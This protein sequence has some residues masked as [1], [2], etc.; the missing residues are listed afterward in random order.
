MLGKR[1]LGS[2]AWFVLIVAGLVI[3]TDEQSVGAAPSGQALLHGHAVIYAR[4]RVRR[5]P[6]GATP[7][8]W[9]VYW[10]KGSDPSEARVLYTSTPG[11][12]PTPARFGYLPSPDGRWLH[13]WETVE[14]NPN[15]VKTQWVV[16]EVS[17][18]RR[19]RI[20]ESPGM[21]G[22]L[23]RW[24]DDHRLRLERGDKSAVFD[25]HTGKISNP[26]PRPQ[27][28][29]ERPEYGE[30]E[31]DSSQAAAAAWRRSYVQR[32]YARDETLL[33]GMQKEHEGELAISPYLRPGK[34][35][36][37]DT[38]ESLL[39]RPL[40]I[41]NLSGYMS[42][43]AVWP[44]VAISPDAKLLARTTFA[45]TGRKERTDLGGRAFLGYAFDARL[46]VYA[47]PSGER[48]WG[49]VVSQSNPQSDNTALYLTHGRLASV[50]D[51][52]FTNPRWSADGLY[53][54]FA[55]VEGPSHR[56]EASVLD[57]T[58]W[59]VALRI[60][61]AIDAFVVSAAE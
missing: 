12:G 43:K 52:W 44:C 15:R 33:K 48:L 55:T 46:D 5:Q 1:G 35:P 10:Q 13:I 58:T 39:L 47:V 19:L 31:I 22:L 40:G 57:T 32:Y 14:L 24:L 20:G 37:P 50:L 16:V 23:P 3:A 17:G 30:R 2:L 9:T 18:A 34:W 28:L 29:P 51:P 49:K 21:V 56:A 45:V 25:V 60:T 53:L 41:V 38:L 6:D 7:T 36:G 61:D 27:T 42:G 4:Q 54:C 26:L 59:R 11:Y 8:E